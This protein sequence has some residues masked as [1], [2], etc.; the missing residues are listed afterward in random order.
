MSSFDSLTLALEGWFETPLCD[1]PDALRQRVEEEFFLMPWDGL[2]AA[3]RRSVALQSDYQD[4]PATEQERRFCSDFVDSMLT[5][6]TQIAKWEAVPTPTARDL[7]LQES[8]LA[9]LRSELAGMWTQVRQARGDNCPVR[10]MIESK[11]AKAPGNTN[12]VAPVGHCA[13]FRAM[14]NLVASELSLAFVG[15]KSE[16]SIGTNNLLEIS[17]RNTTKRVALV[18]LDLVD[19]RRGTLNSQGVILLGLAHKNKLTRD[20]KSAT[21]MKLLRKVF[22]QHLGV[23]GN[24]FEP[25]HQS[26]GWVPLFK[27]SDNRG[28]ADERARQDADRR[29]FS[30]DQLTEFGER[31]TLD[32]PTHSTFEEENDEAGEWLKENDPDASA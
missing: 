10:T 14:E 24:P 25:H 26:F 16:S 20:D 5:I 22:Y 23:T 21:K 28:K 13:E 19:R 27:I 1:L 9:K 17:A 6:E 3:N 7:V 30:Y 8:Q 11:D 18:E 31:F 32:N 2:S 12:E 4:D 29:T 15:D